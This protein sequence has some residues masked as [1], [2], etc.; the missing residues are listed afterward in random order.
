MA[1]IITVAVGVLAVGV[2]VGLF[3]LK[4]ESEGGITAPTPAGYPL[5]PNSVEY[6]TPPY[7]FSTFVFGAIKYPLINFLLG[8]PYIGDLVNQKLQNSAGESG[9][10]RPY[11]LSTKSSYTSWDSLTDKTF[12]GR[13]LPPRQPPAD[14]PPIKEVVKKL[15]TR[16][17][18]KQ[19]MC[20]KSTL[21]FPTFAQHLIDSFINTK[22]GHNGFEWQHTTS[23]HEIGLSPVYGE[24]REQTEQ[25]REK[26]E[27]SGR[28]GRLKTQVLDG[29]EEW[30]PFL[31]DTKGEKKAEFSTLPV[32]FVLEH[33][34][35]QHPSTK[36]AKLRSIFAF[37]GSRANLNPN[38][39]AWNTLLIREHNRLA[40]EIEKSEPSWDDE[41][42][43]QTGRNILIVMYCK[44]V[45]EEY[46]KHI[47]GVNF[48]VAPGEWMWNA[49]WYKTNWMSTEFAILYR[50]HALI[51]NSA[52]WGPSKNIEVLE[53]LYNNPLLLDNQIGLGG[54]L[55]D[56][57]IDISKTRITS[58]QLFNTEKWMIGREGAALKM[59][60]ANNVSSYADYA[61]YLGLGRP[62]TWSDISNQPKVQKALEE[63][64]GTVDR[65]EFWV[66]LIACDH[67]AGG[68]IFSPAMTKFVANDAFNQALTNPLL[69][70][71]VWNNAEATF[72][73]FGF[74]ELTQKVHSIKDMVRRNSPKGTPV[75][76]D[77]FIGM[78]IPGSSS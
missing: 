74:A 40:G 39:V 35:D 43:F 14:L 73:K 12:F 78:T 59:S 41:R 37:G 46:I 65:V 58:F 77:D 6:T 16:E 11:R 62:K 76:D 48:R 75:S 66:G 49:P 47:A 17:G 44:L 69:S 34:L 57:F 38:I 42:V 10:N 1:K 30:A 56:I 8:V 36:D 21:L 70:Q 72:G 19:T 15:F 54:N 27:A 7:A 52:D 50:W 33:L 53:E 22:Y 13:H 3:K 63:L 55:R 71:N 45:I 9:E 20:P 29:G 60:R 64:Y 25:L 28:K 5:P 61:E 23:K 26:S 2:G 18:D 67:G 68:K 51:P 32:P 24:E 31:F 4:K